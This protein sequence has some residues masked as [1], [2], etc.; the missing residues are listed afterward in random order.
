MLGAIFACILAW[1]GLIAATVRFAQVQSPGGVSLPRWFNLPPSARVV[2]MVAFVS[3]LMVLAAG[4][5]DAY[6]QTRVVHASAVEYFQYISIPRLIGISHSHLFGFAVV[7]GLIGLLVA[8]CE[9]SELFK[10]VL[11]AILLW[12]GIFDVFSWWGIKQVSP[13]FEL[14]SIVTGSASGMGVLVSL[15]LIARDLF[16]RPHA[17]AH[18]T[19]GQN[20]ANVINDGTSEASA[21][22]TLV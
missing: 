20:G 16:R 15:G 22:R 17:S 7:Y 1:L 8:M 2:A 13:S 12:S 3:F 9:A 21:A 6:V 19:R 11:V 10:S 18:G 4:A 5:T 14:L